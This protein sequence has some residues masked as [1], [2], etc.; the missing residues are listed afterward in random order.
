MVRTPKGNLI[1]G[2]KWLQ[3]T[4]ANRYHR[5]RKINGKLFQGRYKSLIVEEDGYLGALVHYVHLNPVR[6][7]MVPCERLQDYRWSSYW[8][9]HHKSKRPKFLN[10]STALHKAGGLT[11]TAAGRK[12]YGEYLAWLSGDAEAQKELAFETMCRG[13]ALGS[14]D[15]KKAL[16]KEVV[17]EDDLFAGF[18]GRDLR[19][20]N[21]LMWERTLEAGLGYFEKDQGDIAGDTKS[22]EWKVWIAAVLKKKT[23]APNVWIARRLNMGVPQSVSRHTTR[24]L[25]TSGRSGGE[26]IDEITRITE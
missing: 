23:S 20:A 25:K 15:F 26:L 9:L 13:W 1:Y 5:F 24:L 3:S 18:Q 7:G 11:D 12:C 16:L 22:A 6:A 14:K 21:E 8:Y 10:S 17:V 4:F 2:M 19:E